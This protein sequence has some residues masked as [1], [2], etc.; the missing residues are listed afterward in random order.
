MERD[1]DRL[2]EP[3]P[4]AT[5]VLLPLATRDT[6]LHD[7]Y[8]LAPR[9]A[10]ALIGILKYAQSSRNSILLQ[11]SGPSG[12]C[13][14]PRLMLEEGEW[15]ARRRTSVA[16]QRS[17]GPTCNG[18]ADRRRHI[19]GV[20]NRK[21]DQG[22]SKAFKAS[23]SAAQSSFECQDPAWSRSQP[24][25]P[26]RASSSSSDASAGRSPRSG[27]VPVTVLRLTEAAITA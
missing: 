11:S 16:R 26:S 20:G 25:A 13:V 15:Q 14:A 5:P 17:H 8:L 18:K 4:G 9:S 3:P 22:R 7:I 27:G 1:L 10:A 24:L 6:S 2:D 12:A 23:E 19:G 21:R